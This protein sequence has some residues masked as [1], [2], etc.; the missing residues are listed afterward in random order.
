MYAKAGGFTGD[1]KQHKTDS[2]Q[3]GNQRSG[4]GSQARE[5]ER[6]STVFQMPDTP[7]GPGPR[8]EE[9]NTHCL[10]GRAFLS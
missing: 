7:W 5:A 6:A 2:G 1:S 4:G 10:A 9:P 3:R 8:E